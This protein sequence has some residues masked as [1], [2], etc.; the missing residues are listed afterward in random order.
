MQKSGVMTTRSIIIPVTS[1]KQFFGRSA[2]KHGV[3][4][5]TITQMYNYPKSSTVKLKQ[6]KIE[7]MLSPDA[8]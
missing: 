1:T 8:V 6:L 2:S 5:I 4:Y 7:I 3:C